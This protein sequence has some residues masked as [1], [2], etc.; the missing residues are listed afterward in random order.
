M[1]RNAMS[2]MMLLGSLVLAGMGVASAQNANNGV[3]ER[4][5]GI[6][7]RCAMCGTV[8]S[9]TQNVNNQASTGGSTAATIT[10]SVVGGLI[11]N[12]VGGGR[13]RRAATVGGVVAGG[14]VGNAASSNNAPT[15]SAT[16]RIKLGASNFINVTVDDASDLRV[17]DTVEVDSNGHVVRLR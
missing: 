1:K 5:D 9:I 10:G 8:E 2:K 6:Y 7:L 3:L 11:G 14:A 15:S 4:D 17:G 13:G 12:R 16:V